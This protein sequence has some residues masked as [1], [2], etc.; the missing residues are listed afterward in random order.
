M[1]EDEALMVRTETD[2]AGDDIRVVLTVELPQGVHIEPHEP[3]EPNLIPTVLEIAGLTDV[4]VEYPEPVVTDLGWRGLTLTVL[5]GSVR[6]VVS[7]RAHPGGDGMTGS[8]RY[9]PC[10]GG[11]CLPPRTVVVQAPLTGTSAYALL[12]A[13]TASPPM[14]AG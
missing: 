5:Q 13:L 12:G 9:Q 3:A 1:R 11:A 14:L 8:L 4:T 2:R 7:G 6:F 10:I